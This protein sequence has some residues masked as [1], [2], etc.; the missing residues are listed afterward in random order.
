MA[1][2]WLPKVIGMFH[3]IV[4][5]FGGSFAGK[6]NMVWYDTEVKKPWWTPPKYVFGPVWASLYA[7]MGMVSP[8]W[9]PPIL[10]SLLP[11]LGG[12]GGAVITSKNVRTWY[13]TEIKKPWFKPPNWLF[14]PVWTALYTAMG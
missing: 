5:G 13:D 3:P 2:T 11:H 4:G 12:F 14:A 8:T 7:S 9:A 1:P 10:A 6:E